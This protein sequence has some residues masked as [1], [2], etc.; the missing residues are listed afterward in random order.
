MEPKFDNV[1]IITVAPV[2]A[3]PTKKENPNVPLTPE[4]V[5]EE[6]EEEPTET[7][8]EITEE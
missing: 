6:V 8:E 5:A 7:E 3:W 2:G 4:E 1:R